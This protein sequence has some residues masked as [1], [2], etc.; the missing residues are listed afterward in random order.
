MS[1]RLL[2]ADESP[3]IKK[4]FEIALKDFGVKV[5][6]V[7]QGTDVDSVFNEFQPEICFLDVLLQKKNGYEVSADLNQS[8]PNVPVVLMWSGFMELDKEKFVE[9]GAKAS[10]EKPF[11][12]NLLREIVTKNVPRLKTN[13]ISDFLEADEVKTF[14]S[15]NAPTAEADLPDLPPDLPALDDD[16]TD[17]GVELNALEADLGLS[18]ETSTIE[19]PDLDDILAMPGDITESSDADDFSI[20]DDLEDFVLED[21]T[22]GPLEAGAPPLPSEDDSDAFSM[23]PLQSVDISSPAEL[24]PIPSSEQ[25]APKEAEPAQPQEEPEDKQSTDNTFNLD[26]QLSKEELK[27]IIMA[28]SKDI[29]ESVVWDVVP[30]LAKEMIRKEIRRLTGDIK[31]KEDLR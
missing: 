21:P 12:T 13:E 5:Q 14:T 16:V 1:L 22:G 26:S 2:L 7:H 11:E 4:A 19:T 8:H 28:Q 25:D 10:L 17:P 20:V 3:S 18:I 31:P 6:T 9:C 29:I 15:D 23:E 24:P 30:E 27:R